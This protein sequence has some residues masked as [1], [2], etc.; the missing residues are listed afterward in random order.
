MVSTT[1]TF[2]IVNKSGV[3]S[4]PSASLVK[5]ANRFKSSI[6]LKHKN[7]VVDG[8]SIL[9]VMLLSAGCGDQIQVTATGHDSAQAV[10]EIG[11]LIASGFDEE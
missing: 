8:K 2:K 3:H 10:D 1:N 9:G 7:E 11:K 4:R 6:N 5:L